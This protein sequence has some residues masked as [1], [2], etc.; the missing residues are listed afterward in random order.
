MRYV[1]KNFA[2]L[3]V[4]PQKSWIWTVL[5]L[6]IIRKKE[7]SRVIFDSSDLNL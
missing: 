4:S 3:L 7:T 2:L 6:F 5:I 1:A